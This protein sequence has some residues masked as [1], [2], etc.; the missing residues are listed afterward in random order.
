MWSLW[1][2]QPLEVRMP[3]LLQGETTR[4]GVMQGWPQKKKENIHAIDTAEQ[5]TETLPTEPT[6]AP[7]QTKQQRIK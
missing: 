2:V 6:S 3:L 4:P 7:H 1:Q 5:S